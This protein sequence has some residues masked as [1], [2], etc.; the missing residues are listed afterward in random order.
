MVNTEKLQKVML[1]LFVVLVFFIVIYLVIDTFFVN[2]VTF[3]VRLKD[4]SLN[5]GEVGTVNSE[6]RNLAFYGVWDVSVESY[7]V[8]LDSV[9]NVVNESLGKE[10]ETKL[11]SVGGFTAKVVSYDFGTDDLEP[12][13]YRVYS[14][15]NWTKRGVVVSDWKSKNFRIA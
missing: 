15:A 4:R 3:R 10:N 1:V 11:G 5:R 7:I 9:G 12:G 14:F 8:M 13:R 2:P 6:V